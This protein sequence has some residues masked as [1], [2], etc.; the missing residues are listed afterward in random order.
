M[1]FGWR[2]SRGERKGGGEMRGGGG[3]AK[4]TEKF[5]VRQRK[6]KKDRES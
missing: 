5:R 3:R 1:H 6:T 2:E 4:E